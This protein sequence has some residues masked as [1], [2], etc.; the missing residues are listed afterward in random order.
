[1]FYRVNNSKPQLSPLPGYGNE[2]AERERERER[3]SS[4]DEISEDSPK[5]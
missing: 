3:E 1:M 4:D 2:N 5:V